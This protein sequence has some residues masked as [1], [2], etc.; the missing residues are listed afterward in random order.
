MGVAKWLVCVS[1]WLLS[2]AVGCVTY[3]PLEGARGCEAYAIGT[4]QTYARCSPML[5]EAYSSIE[6]C[7]AALADSCTSGL[8]Q[9]DALGSGAG[10][11]A[12]GLQMSALDCTALW[13]GELPWGCQPPA[14]RRG[15][16]APCSV[17]AQCASTRCEKLSG[18]CAELALV[19][20]SC[21]GFGDC[22]YGLVC[23]PAQQCIALAQ[24]GQACSDIQPCRSPLYCSNAV[25]VAEL[26]MLPQVELRDPAVE[27]DAFARAL[28]TRLDGCSKFLV[29]GSY[30]SMQACVA[31]TT[32]TCT[33]G[34]SLP[35]TAATALGL[36]GCTAALS[37]ASCNAVL[38]NAAPEACRLVPGARPDGAACASDSQC[39]S[40]RC[41]HTA[42]SARCGVCAARAQAEAFCTASSDCEYG[43]VCTSDSKC[44][45]PAP[46]GAPCDTTRP[47]AMPL[48]CAA[49][50]CQAALQQGAS[51]DSA[52]DHCD[53]FAGLSCD[54]TSMRCATWTQSAAGQACGYITQGWA[55]CIGSARCNLNSNTWTGTC[56][57]PAADSGACTVGGPSCLAPARCVD[58]SCVLGSGGDCL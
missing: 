35:D 42:A 38:E 22:S 28:C 14:G 21:V 58:G 51:C 8:R 17:G 16:G 19:G 53:T 20:Q 5:I 39:A 41:S 13:N 3:D 18:T 37:D 10:A 6:G 45:A 24:F 47:C 2:A 54:Y 27:C 31:R 7:V 12:C 34:L 52:A 30:G 15:D 44:R 55:A 4:C 43:L 25:C 49:G 32:Q 33:D 23:G 29:P 26:P 46:E 56:E 9:P 50:I 57:A 40:T 1:C 11:E 36:A 48:L